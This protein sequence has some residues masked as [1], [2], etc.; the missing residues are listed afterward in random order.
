MSRNEIPL[1]S[2][3]YGLI[4]RI[5]KSYEVTSQIDRDEYLS[6]AG[7]VWTNC[8]TSFNPELN[9]KFI[10]YF[11]YNFKWR[12]IEQINVR[13]QRQKRT[14]EH[15]TKT[16]NLDETSKAPG[17]NRQ[18]HEFCSIKGSV[19][20]IDLL[21]LSDHAKYMILE[22]YNT[23]LKWTKRKYNKQDLFLKVNQ[24]VKLKYN[25]TKQI[26]AVHEI[27]D[28]I[29]GYVSSKNQPRLM[30]ITFKAPKG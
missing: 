12:A 6:L 17:S 19:N 8:L 3:Y 23:K 9:T 27:A 14:L 2:D 28:L 5:S 16:I 21:L 11:L 22:L 13:A 15:G 20:T 18:N 26:E 24:K 10:T 29:G 30:A 7:L 25:R 4:L 1:F